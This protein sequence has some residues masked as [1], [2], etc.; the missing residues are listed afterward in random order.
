MSGCVTQM[1]TSSDNL[2]QLLKGFT[3]ELSHFS[4]LNVLLRGVIE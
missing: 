2:T 3:S 4:Q 1:G